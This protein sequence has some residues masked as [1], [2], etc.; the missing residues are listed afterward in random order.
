MDNTSLAWLKEDKRYQK[1]PYCKKGNLS[2]RLKSFRFYKLIPFVK[3]KRYRCD[4]CEK[5]V[6]VFIKR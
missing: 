3:A 4:N 1:C 2:E 5:T 6:H